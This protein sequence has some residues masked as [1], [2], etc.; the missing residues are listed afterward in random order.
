MEQFFGPAVSSTSPIV[1]LVEYITSEVNRD[2]F[3]KSLSKGQDLVK[4]Y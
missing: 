4:A 3:E 2:T 1:R